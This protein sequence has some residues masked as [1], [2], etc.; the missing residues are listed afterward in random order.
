MEDDEPQSR[1][2]GLRPPGGGLPPFITTGF[3]PEP[4]ND[5]G[6]FRESATNLIIRVNLRSR[7]E[8]DG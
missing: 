7:F 4:G 5:S 2:S 6:Q 3:S 1:P 8:N